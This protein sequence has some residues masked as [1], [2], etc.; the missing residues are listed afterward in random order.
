MTQIPGYQ[1]KFAIKVETGSYEKM[2]RPEDMAAKT[3]S[4]ASLSIVTVLFACSVIDMN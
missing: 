4:D 3:N 1:V 2:K